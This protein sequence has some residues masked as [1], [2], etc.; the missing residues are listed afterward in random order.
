MATNV[1][2]A[3]A[4]LTALGGGAPELERAVRAFVSKYRPDR[5]PAAM[6]AED[7]A[8]VM[9]TV[10]AG[11]VEETVYGEELR[12]LQEQARLEVKPFK[13]NKEKQE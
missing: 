9:L 11:L 8:E 5:D 4:V 2:Q 12:E 13:L 1:Q 7:R 3:K 6:P 10:L